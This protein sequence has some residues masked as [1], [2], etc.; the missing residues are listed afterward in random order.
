MDDPNERFSQVLFFAAQAGFARDVARASG[1]CRA[2]YHDER[3][4]ELLVRLRP[5]RVWNRKYEEWVPRR[6]PL[7]CA[8]RA[9]VK[10]SS[11]Q[12]RAASAPSTAGAAAPA[13]PGAPAAAIPPAAAT[14]GPQPSALRALWL[15]ER[16]ADPDGAGPSLIA[17]LQHA[18]HLR[19]GAL[20]ASLLERG[21]DP[22]STVPFHCS[23]KN[24]GVHILELALDAGDEAAVL[25]LLRAGACPFLHEEH[26]PPPLHQA[27]K[28]LPRAAV[29][30]AL[31]DSLLRAGRG[32]DSRDMYGRT[33]LHVA[34][35]G[36]HAEVI[37]I[38]LFRGARV[39]E[40][41]VTRRAR[42]WQDPL[43]ESGDESE[44]ERED[45]RE[46]EGVTA[47][48][49]AL[50]LALRGGHEAAALAL[51]AADATLPAKWR[52]G[53]YGSVC[54][55]PTFIVLARVPSPAVV[56]AMLARGAD[57][58][59]R[60]YDGRTL[61]HYAAR[62]GLADIASMLLSAGADVHAKDSRYDAPPLHSATNRAVACLLLS[63]G[64]RVNAVCGR[65]RTALHAA[66]IAGLDD[67]VS[68]LI[69]HGA[70]VNATPP[71]PAASTDDSSSDDG[72]SRGGRMR[73]GR[74]HVPPEPRA[75]TALHHV[76]ASLFDRGHKAV[77]HALLAAGA[78]PWALC[79][80]G[81]TPL[82]WACM[83]GCSSAVSVLLA[84]STAGVNARVAVADGEAGD[85]PLLLALRRAQRSEC[86]DRAGTLRAVTMLLAAG[87]DPNV[88]GGDGAAALG[89][90]LEMGCEEVAM[91]LVTRGANVRVPVL[92][93]QTPLQVA[94][95]ARKDMGV[96][97]VDALCNAG[98]DPNAGAEAPGQAPLL[99]ALGNGHV[100]FAGALLTH[101]V[102][103]MPPAGPNGLT[104]L[105]LSAKCGAPGMV[106]DLLRRGADPRARDANG[107]TPLHALFDG[108]GYLR[109]RSGDDQDERL[110]AAAA[111]LL[112][113]GADANAADASGA[114]PLL[115]AARECTLSCRV[116]RA[117][118][119]IVLLER[120]ADP[121]AADRSGATPLHEAVRCRKQPLVRV[122]L[123]RG[124]DPT[125]VDADGR[126]A[127][128]H[129]IDNRFGGVASDLLARDCEA[130]LA[131]ASP[132]LGT[133]LHHA[134]RTAFYDG[135]LVL[136]A[137]GADVAER[138]PVRG[139]DVSAAELAE[140]A[141]TETTR[142]FFYDFDDFERAHAVE[143]I[144][145]AVRIAAT[146][147][148]PWSH[149][150]AA[151]GVHGVAIAS[152]AAPPV[153]LPGMSPGPTA[154][155]TQPQALSRGLAPASG[156]AAPMGT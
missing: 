117:D 33:A 36:G 87:A 52:T 127:L 74:L 145:W 146:G 14:P 96:A 109:L 50:E 128:H 40:P 133:P 144:R 51:L 151:M 91:E 124:A 72:Y 39:D 126:I 17:P 56:A 25:A 130:Q 121:R 30:S 118:A 131:C 134:V 90:A 152:T 125:A 154:E 148:P 18:I 32:V 44:D 23:P 106:S 26:R 5:G 34:A 99:L 140:E 8:L 6:S 155:A 19:D 156:G 93:G 114:T 35:E 86:T 24:S 31:L 47:G 61:L 45:E 46:D 139:R 136:L 16:G 1:T 57:P 60:S 137:C 111:A 28:A 104:A 153:P 108:E 149:I 9:A 81:F 119:A 122:L 71:P 82:H 112:D 20:L 100:A 141:A 89:I 54:E 38:L 62:E 80:G 76:A 7:D 97:V 107:R 12:R 142:P 11:A 77:M 103:T 83:V 22:D 135:V 37:R 67:V 70:C 98:G 78:D 88:M 53:S 129:A 59:A 92:T 85:T 10:A 69:A 65:G 101:G 15:L 84:H 113:H 43:N 58:H 115:F 21:A 68:V 55:P 138:A 48:P 79:A 42:L 73:F 132:A 95:R 75:A 29:V 150:P 4:W 110:A 13:V 64:A 143:G 147:P 3:L 49:T 66:A 105:H 123:D 120:G 63:H 41:V 94:C 116:W 27:C 2:V 102:A